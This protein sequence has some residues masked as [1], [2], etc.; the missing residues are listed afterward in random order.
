M[1]GRVFKSSSP[2]FS[3]EGR[4]IFFDDSYEHEADGCN[5]ES[6]LL[7]DVSTCFTEMI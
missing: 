3:K 1:H 7:I 4:C 6:L 5:K 2:D